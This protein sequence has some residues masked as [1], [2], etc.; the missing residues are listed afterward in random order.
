MKTSSGMI[1]TTACNIDNLLR[2]SCSRE[3]MERELA[4]LLSDAGKEAFLCA[5]ASQLF[6]WRHLMLHSQ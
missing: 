4:S 5:L 2:S 6:I 1:N 3:E